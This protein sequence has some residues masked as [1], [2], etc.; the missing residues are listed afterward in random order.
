M[1]W[2]RATTL[3]TVN[4]I[5]DALVALAILPMAVA[6]ILDSP[7]WM[8]SIAAADAAKLAPVGRTALWIVP[9]ILSIAIVLILSRRRW[10]A[11]PRRGWL[12]KVFVSGW[13][14]WTDTLPRSDHSTHWLFGWDFVLAT[15]QWMCRYAVLPILVAAFGY[16]AYALP[17]LFVQGVLLF[18]ATLVVVPGGG[19]SVELATL[20]LLGLVMPVGVAAIIVVSWRFLTQYVYLGAG[21]LGVAIMVALPENA[22]AD[23]ARA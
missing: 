10:F 14:L 4:A 16:G 2:R 23:P 6:A 1:P 15:G 3:T 5:T 13:R 22:A 8:G 20:A 11:G 9:L 17:L 7:E 12:T 18:A 21:A 19:G